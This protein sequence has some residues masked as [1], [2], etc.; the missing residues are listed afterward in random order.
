MN[1]ILCV[2]FPR[3][4]SGYLWNAVWHLTGGAFK[5]CDTHQEP[6]DRERHYWVKTHDFGMC[7][8]PATEYPDSQLIVQVRNPADAIVSFFN[9]QLNP[10]GNAKEDTLEGWREFYPWA[11]DY[12]N[13]FMDRW[14]EWPGAYLVFHKD[15]IPHYKRIVRHVYAMMMDEQPVTPFVLPPR[16]PFYHQS[17]RYF[18]AEDFDKI[19]ELCGE[20]M[21][22]FNRAH[23]AHGAAMPLDSAAK[24]A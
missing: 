11:C 5:R 16:A 14:L 20:R 8:D 19:Y 23:E 10:N 18:H 13:K 15:L 12:W 22:K 9:Y 24:E 7:V 21:V 6:Y 4:G 2:S 3:S 1:R 17:F